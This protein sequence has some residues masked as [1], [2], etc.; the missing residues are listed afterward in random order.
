MVTIINYK[1][2]TADDGREFFALE[3]NGGVEM[4]KS[5]ETGNFYATSKKTSISSTFDEVTCKALIGT[6]IAGTVQKVE[7]EPYE[8]VSKDTG[9]VMLLQHRYIYSPDEQ[10]QSEKMDKTIQFQP[11]Y[12]LA[13]AV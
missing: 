1:K 6:Q 3:V 9:E 5:N 13:S 10:V 8:Y 11:N 12:E 7:C 2:R 4:V